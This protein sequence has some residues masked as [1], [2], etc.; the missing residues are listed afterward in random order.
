MKKI[1]RYHKH[2]PLKDYIKTQPKSVQAA[3]KREA[4]RLAKAHTEA[5][6]KDKVIKARV[7]IDNN[8]EVW[9]SPFNM[10]DDGVPCLITIKAADW[11]KIKGGR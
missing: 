10:P 9:A 11:K 5:E 4:K 2:M 7:V 6:A 1:D 8:S 3:Y